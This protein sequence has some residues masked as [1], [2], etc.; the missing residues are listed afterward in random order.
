MK[1][2][3]V[4]LLMVGLWGMTKSGCLFDPSGASQTEPRPDGWIDGH[5]QTDADLDGADGTS[6]P[7]CG[8][9]VK[10]PGEECDGADLGGASC[11][12]LG[13]GEGQLSC[14]NDCHYDFG[15][16]A[17]CGNGVADPGEDCDGSDL[18]STTCANL[19]GFDSGLLS[20]TDGCRFDTTGCI[21]CGNGVIEGQEQCDATNLNGETCASRGYTAGVLQCNPSCR[22]DESECTECGN[23]EREGDEAC[24][25]DDFGGANSCTD[26][27]YDYGTLSCAPDCTVDT[28]GCE[29]CGNGNCVEPLESGGVCIEDCS[30]PLFEFDFESGWP[31]EWQTRDDND[32]SGSDTWAP[33]NDRSQ[34][35]SHS[36]WC[37]ENGDEPVYL[38]GYA[39]DMDAHAVHAFD[40]SAYSGENLRVSFWFWCAVDHG[41]DYF[42]FRWSADGGSSWHEDDSMT[43]DESW[44]W[45][46]IDV[47]E[48]AGAPN[49]QIDFYFRA[50]DFL[51][52]SDGAY[53]DDLVLFYWW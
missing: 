9:G 17:L 49:A 29:R 32:D 40:L 22:F 26:H 36:L 41:E 51:S 8:N 48:L 35:G 47:N 19:S 46:E 39:N 31:G 38:G 5:P 12:S 27:N 52:V 42:R 20:C 6:D 53:V 21:G 23:G 43:C 11:D 2:Q 15:D 24:D 28:S 45:V 37:A 50:D 4:I 30:E 25:Q 7:V 1:T 34:S 13:Q 33:S 3:F 44:H 16:C 10:E 14:T 18:R